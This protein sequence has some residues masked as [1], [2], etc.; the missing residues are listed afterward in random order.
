MFRTLILYGLMRLNTDTI[1]QRLGQII[2]NSLFDAKRDRVIKA[3][4][5]QIENESKVTFESKIY[6]SVCSMTGIQF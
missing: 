6:F 5:T 4:L 1:K 3:L 2:F